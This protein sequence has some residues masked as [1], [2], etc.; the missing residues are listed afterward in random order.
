MLRCLH[1]NCSSKHSSRSPDGCELKHY[2]G[3]G[4]TA[5][6]RMEAIGLCCSTEPDRS[7]TWSVTDFY[8]MSLLKGNFPYF[9][10][11]SL[12]KYPNIHYVRDDLANICQFYIALMVAPVNN[13]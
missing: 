1:S 3:G 8:F 2:Y 4:F 11:L 12:P 9:V 6:L 10:V 5:G 13:I 7:A